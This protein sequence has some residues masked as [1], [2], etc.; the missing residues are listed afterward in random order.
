M[1]DSVGKELNEDVNMQ[2]QSSIDFGP[3]V[4]GN[5]IRCLKAHS[6]QLVVDK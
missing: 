6:P 4:M 5:V 2:V 1:S 3:K